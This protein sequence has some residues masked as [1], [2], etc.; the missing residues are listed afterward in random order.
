MKTLC[1]RVVL[2]VFS[3]LFIQHAAQAQVAPATQQP[4]ATSVNPIT[5]DK[6]KQKK[7]KVKKQWRFAIDVDAGAASPNNAE[8]SDV[9]KAGVNASLGVKTAFLNNKLWVRP[10]A[11]LK[12]YFKNVE[13]GENRREAF[14]TWKG[15]IELQY[16]A[17]TLKKFSFCPMLKVNQNLSSSQF[18]KLADDK[19]N[20][21][22]IQ[23][24]ADVLKGTGI[25][26]GGGIMVVHSGD[27]YVKLDYE[28][29]K[30]DL[31]VSPE[32]IREMLAAG[33][34]MPDHKVYDCSSIN[35]SIGFNL[36]FK[37]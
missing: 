7:P 10:H 30:P 15:G 14:R 9:F 34:L 20:S 25:S 37:K 23:T 28:Y 21:T 3:V 1:I 29:Y 31:K 27:L 36:N 5:L 17:Y 35:L 32:L 24:T 26:F 16:N 13:L 22:A 19:T 6:E 2:W 33:Y 8:L 18:T 11:G 12:Y 4:Q